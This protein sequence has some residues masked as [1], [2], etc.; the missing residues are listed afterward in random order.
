M[1]LVVSWNLVHYVNLLF[2]ANNIY[3]DSVYLCDFIQFFTLTTIY[4]RH[5]PTLCIFLLSHL[6]LVLLVQVQYSGIYSSDVIDTKANNIV[7]RKVQ[8]LFAQ[9]FFV[10]IRIF[11][12][13][14]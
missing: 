5:F 2:I 13:F 3:I 4:Y 7:R 12:A 6:S 1:G 8:N 9:P 11:L 14:L 10:P